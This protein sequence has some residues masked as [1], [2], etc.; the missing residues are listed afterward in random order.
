MRA[1]V[2]CLV[3][4][5]SVA[6]SAPAQAA[7]RTSSAPTVTD[8]DPAARAAAQTAAARTPRLVWR[9]C[10]DGLQ[11]ATAEVP[12]DYDRPRGETIRLALVKLPATAPAR[13]IGTLFVN[14]GGPG[15]SGTALVRQAGRFL[16]APEVLARF[17]LVGFDPRGVAQST[18]VRCFATPNAQL[19]WFSAQP[20]FPVT[21]REEAQVTAANRDLATRCASRAGRLL[22]HVSTAD[23]ARDLELLRRAVGDRRLTYAGYSYGTFL[24]T[25]YANLFPRRVRALVLDGAI[26]PVAWTTGRGAAADRQPLTTRTRSDEGASN[27]LRHFF[28]TCDA[29][30]RRCDFSPGDPQARYAALAERLRK[31]P[32]RI[33]NPGG[34]VFTITYADMVA[35]TL[36]LL[37]SPDR[38]VDLAAFLQSLDE[39]SSAEPAATSA[40]GLRAALA[41][42]GA[43]VQ[44]PAADDDYDN[45]LE[46][47][48]AVACVDSDNPDAA[49]RWGVEGRRAD[50]RSAY[51]G[52]AWTWASG[53]CAAW[54]A[55]A[56]D[57][58]TGPWDRRTAAP[59]LVVANRYDPAT[60]HYS[61]VVLDRLL[62]R[63]R[64]LTL[65]GAGHTSL[66]QSTCI[67]RRVA[68]Y[69][70][71]GVLPPV[72][73]SCPPD[74]DPFPPLPTFG[75]QDRSA[76]RAGESARPGSVLP[77]P[78][79]VRRVVDRLLH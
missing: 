50:A 27:A 3:A 56:P 33:I 69:L 15:G 47:F 13:R 29:A 44:S 31:K 78:A 62:P 7:E 37:Y 25:V 36:A 72:G 21:A 17:D 6:V 12:L 63:S 64:L 61:G 53:P 77:A 14:P 57:R 22:T 75:T 10:G 19:D 28:R 55:A 18:P 73:A 43:A 38:W 39:L 26:D 71:R 51:F 60:R 2:A 45:G 11:C 49:W 54:P 70:V 48:P 52:R 58:Y 4:L 74:R 40:A 68:A 66:V 23:V 5:A 79:P 16:Y 41:A 32:F 59:V 65:E 30:G 1:L 24:G 46:A 42:A 35:L 34:T 9:G 8:A 20:I 76:A 67:D